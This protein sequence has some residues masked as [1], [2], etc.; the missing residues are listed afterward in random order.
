MLQ[1]CLGGK[2]CTVIG[3]ALT[4]NLSVSSSSMKN[5][6][7]IH[8]F[9]KKSVNKRE[10]FCC[11]I[12]R[13]IIIYLLD[14]CFTMVINILTPS[15]V[16]LHQGLARSHS[17]SRNYNPKITGVGTTSKSK[18]SNTYT[19]CLTCIIQPSISCSERLE[20]MVTL[21][22]LV[23]VKTTTVMRIFKYIFKKINLKSIYPQATT[24]LYK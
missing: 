5:Q 19:M 16:Y 9:L 6:F 23:E 15:C 13:I 2:K 18:V 4:C 8:S 7:N 21:Y 10:Y 20:K 14:V 24:N 3:V 1:L 17:F 12:S 22:N 11:E